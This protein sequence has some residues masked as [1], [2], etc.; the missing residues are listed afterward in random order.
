MKG[1]NGGLPYFHDSE[2]TIF[3]KNSTPLI[4]K[5]A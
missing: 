4:K 5:H 2:K 1:W 3:R